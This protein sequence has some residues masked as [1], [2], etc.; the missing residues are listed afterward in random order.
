MTGSKIKAGQGGSQWNL[1]LLACVS[2]AAVN[3]SL[4]AARKTSCFSRPSKR[5]LSDPRGGALSM[6]GLD[7]STTETARA[8]PVP[9]TM[10]TATGPGTRAH[11]VAVTSLVAPTRRIDPTAGD[12]CT[13]GGLHEGLVQGVF[14]GVK[15]RTF[16][17]QPPW[18]DLR[19]PEK[20]LVLTPRS[21]R[22]CAHHSRSWLMS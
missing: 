4:G 9:P 8:T 21:P 18:T 22:A 20:R 16:F 12:R 11:L 6:T 13:S 5:K 3:P 1:G 19:R 17:S 10:S 2:P 14:Q 15:N 7:S